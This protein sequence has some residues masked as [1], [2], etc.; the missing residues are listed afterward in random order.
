MVSGMRA[1]GARRTQ[2]DAIQIVPLSHNHFFLPH[3]YP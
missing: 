2:S 1:N 3:S